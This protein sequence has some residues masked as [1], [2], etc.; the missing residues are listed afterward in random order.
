MKGNSHAVANKQALVDLP[1]Y[2]QKKRGKK[3]KFNIEI[4][5]TGCKT[6]VRRRRKKTGQ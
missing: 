3:H 6:K 1:V 2:L 5:K 4:I